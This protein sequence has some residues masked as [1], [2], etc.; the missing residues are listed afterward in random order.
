ME[1]MIDEMNYVLNCRYES[2]ECYDP[3]MTSSH[4]MWL[5]SLVGQSHPKVPGLNPVEV[6]NFSGFSKQLLKLHS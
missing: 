2:K 6:L 5:H 3:Q 1:E 4:H